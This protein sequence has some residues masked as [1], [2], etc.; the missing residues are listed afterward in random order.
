MQMM[1]IG[2]LEITRAL[3]TIPF[4]RCD[5]V[6][7]IAQGGIVPASLI[8]FH[9][10]LD[11]ALLTVEYR[12]ADNRPLYDEPLV[13][14]GIDAFGRLTQKDGEDAP[15][16]AQTVL[17]VDD[18]AVTGK[19]LCVAREAL[20]NRVRVITCVLRGQ[21]DVVVFPDLAS[22]VRWPWRQ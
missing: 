22:C 17:L 11:L 4:P 18:V 1:S 16:T 20:G 10:S 13:I 21:A 7:G 2:F 12:G 19:T 5:M 14:R 3:R 8:A 15:D 9:L 6:V